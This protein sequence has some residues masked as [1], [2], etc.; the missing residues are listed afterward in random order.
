MTDHFDPRVPQQVKQK[1]KEGNM[2][3]E[4]RSFGQKVSRRELLRL[5]GIGG[6][7]LL[8][9][10]CAPA[11]PPAPSAAPQQA[12]PTAAV[13]EKPAPT[14]APAEQGH[15]ITVAWHTGGEG[16]NK[17][18]A[19]AADLFEK[20]HPNYKLERIM[21]PWDQYMNKILVMYASGTAPD[22]HTI[23]WG[24]YAVFAEK[25]G[26]LD[27]GPL[28]ERDATDLKPEDFWPAAWDGM[29]YKGTRRALPRETMG[30]FLVAYNKDLFDQAGIQ[31]PADLYEAGEWTWEKWREV[32]GQLAKRSGDRF[33]QVGGNFPVF[34]EGFDISMR[35][36]GLKGGLYDEA[37]TTIKLT[38][39]LTYEFT[40]WLQDVI[41]K[42]KSIIPPGESEEFDWMASGKQAM[43][44]DATWAIPNWR[45][46][47]KFAWDFAPPPKGKGGFF[48]PAGYD[49]YGINGKTKDPDGAWEFIKYQNLPDMTLWWG[50]KMFG[51]PFHKSVADKWLAS[52]GANPPPS[53]GWKYMPDMANASISVI[54]TVA[55]QLWLN[56]WD[57]KI[58]PVFRGDQDA[59]TVYPEVKTEMEK[60]LVSGGSTS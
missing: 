37:L 50:E 42:D 47:W 45:E 33:D 54:N 51:M 31:N 18:F 7:S 23:P 56:E 49:F 58:I 16:A 2:S 17:V 9:A 52:V 3:K 57:N 41:T 53:R 6:V 5:A 24:W 1:P 30:M 36:W 11:P 34:N 25:G 20:D 22:A 48:E 12:A 27:I 60:A 10:A 40:A 4:N 35:S 39:P 29:L 59:Q 28:A 46:A 21:A 32:A 55:Q 14:Q 13:E 19:E 38:D 8:A 44:N 43:V 15:N 26:L